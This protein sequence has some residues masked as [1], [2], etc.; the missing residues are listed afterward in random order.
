M[1]RADASDGG[2]LL[3]D[4]LGDAIE[5]EWFLE[6]VG[7][8]GE[9]VGVEVVLLHRRDVRQQRVEPVVGGH[10]AEVLGALLDHLLVFTAAREGDGAIAQAS[11]DSAG[12]LVA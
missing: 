2:D 6:G 8:M 12:P 11:G 4:G 3:V 10:D 1:L 9:G 7:D 5:C